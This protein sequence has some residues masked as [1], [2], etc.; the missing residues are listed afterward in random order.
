[1]PPRVPRANEEATLM[2]GSSAVDKE[3]VAVDLMDACTKIFFL[4]RN[5]TLRKIYTVSSSEKRGKVK[6]V[7]FRVTCSAAFNARENA[8]NTNT[9]LTITIAITKEQ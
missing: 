8:K 5:T 6:N 9:S 4:I 1:M 7:V 3:Y 2:N